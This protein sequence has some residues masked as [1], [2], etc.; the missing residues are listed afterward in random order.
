MNPVFNA[1]SRFEVSLFNFIG[2][3][4]DGYGVITSDDGG[5]IERE[6]GFCEVGGVGFAPYKSIHTGK[7]NAI[8]YY[9]S[10][11]KT[12][13]TLNKSTRYAIVRGNVGHITDNRANKQQITQV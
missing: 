4:R 10:I 12:D 6:N 2:M 11:S 5:Q 13:L 1:F 8:L 9:T 3:F 7:R